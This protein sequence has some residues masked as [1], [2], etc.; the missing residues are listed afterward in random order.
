[1]LPSRPHGPRS[2]VLDRIPDPP[3]CASVET[4]AALAT[5]NMLGH[6]TVGVTGWSARDAADVSG[7]PRRVEL[8]R[9]WATTTC[10]AAVRLDGAP[11]TTTDQSRR[12]DGPWDS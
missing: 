4:Q 9:R 11:T 8:T 5:R 7:P 3:D 10:I 12:H 2:T 6:W 1:M